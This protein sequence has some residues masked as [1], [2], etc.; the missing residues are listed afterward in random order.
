MVNHTQVPLILCWAATIHKVQG[1]SLDIAVIDLGPHVFG[2]GMTYVALSHVR[3]LDG[4]ALL[5]LSP[6]RVSASPFVSSEMERLRHQAQNGVKHSTSLAALSESSRQSSIS[7]LAQSISKH[8]SLPAAKQKCA[9]TCVPK[10][11]SKGS[12]SNKKLRQSVQLHMNVILK[13]TQVD[14]LKTKLGHSEKTI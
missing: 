11:Y 14:K 3:S 10:Q 12:K 6:K 4:V 9:C 1:L 5:S 8:R 7:C 13:K 2:Y